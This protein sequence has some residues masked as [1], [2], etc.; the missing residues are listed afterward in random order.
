MAVLAAFGLLVAV[1]PFDA[2]ATRPSADDPTAG[3]RLSYTAPAGCPDRS[4]LLAALAQRVDPAWHAGFDRRRFVLRID[5]LADG[6]FSGRL[7]VTREGRESQTETREVRAE[8]CRAVSAALVVFIA[9]ALDPAL[10]I[11]PE[12]SPPEPG[13]IPPRT[14]RPEAAPLPSPKPAATRPPPAS[15]HAPPQGPAWSWGSIVDVAYVHA[16]HDAWGARVHGQLART[17][18]G[19]RIAPAL[20]LSWGFAE[21]DTR[22]PNGGQASFRFETARAS[23]CA[24]VALAPAPITVTPCVGLDFGSLTAMSRNLPQVGHTSTPWS[25]L[26]GGLRT[27]LSV[28]PWLTLDAEVGA[29]APF[30]RTTFAL[31]EPIR[32]VYRAPSVIFTAC[33]GLAV[34]ARFP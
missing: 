27:S 20:R 26:S 34:S 29:L 8:T 17:L 31:V 33:A 1:W 7:E 24:L 13:P 3:L 2:G 18:L 32:V 9:I 11:E 28:L 30:T 15:P 16:P 6:A 10:D 21:F 25:A 12:P 23:A 4:E 22:P 5:H 14:P 19:T